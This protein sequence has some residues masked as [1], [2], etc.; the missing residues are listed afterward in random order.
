M[1]AYDL[2]DLPDGSDVFL[3]ANIL[4]Y[5][6]TNQSRDS[7]R[8][9]ERCSTETVTGI[10]SFSV[11]AEATH[12]L[13]L[14]EARQKGL[15]TRSAPCTLCG[16]VRDRGV[17]YLKEHPEQVRLLADYWDYVVRLL[18]LNILLLVSDEAIVRNAHVARQTHGF[19]TNDSM[20]VATMREYG[21]SRLATNDAHFR[22]LT[23]VSV[24]EARDVT[25]P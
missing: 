15:Y 4:I 2:R 11:I 24:F 9:L 18:D 12:E 3:D 14:G 22:E 23:D 5:G 17:R 8:L 1:P 7:Y 13:M 10:T 21:I 19:L 6:V 25:T 20:I 16:V